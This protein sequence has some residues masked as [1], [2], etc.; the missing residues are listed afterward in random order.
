VRKDAPWKDFKE[1][2][3]ATKAEPGK[4]L[5][6]TT[7]R[8]GAFLAAR[9]V[10]RRAGLQVTVVPYS[11]SGPYVTAVL[12]G[13][14]AAAIAPVTS[15]ESHLAG[16][17]L[18]M[19]AVTGPKRLPDHPNVPSFSEFGIDAPFALWVGLVAPKDVPANRL[20]YLREHIAKITK[21][22]EYLA[23][24]K[25]L[26]IAV[27]YAPPDEFEKQVRAESKSFNALVKE[28]GL[29]PK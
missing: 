28:L 29:A 14:V 13:H 8:G 2:Q 21:D 10:I 23:A 5:M 25:K 4:I 6:G 9:D 19:L 3:A 18:R 22:P 26:G 7:P 27:D 24:A 16:G 12:G 17:T 11:G 20:A 1:F 15:L